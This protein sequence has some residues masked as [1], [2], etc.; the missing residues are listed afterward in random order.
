LCPPLDLTDE[1]QQYRKNDELQRKA[2]KARIE[3]ILSPI[4]TL[5]HR[6]KISKRMGINLV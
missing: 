1:L 6:D 5:E 3:R 2:D 4:L